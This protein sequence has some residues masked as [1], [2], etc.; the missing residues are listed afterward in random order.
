MYN[1]E[2]LY[3]EKIDLDTLLSDSNI[4]IAHNNFE[5]AITET[6]NTH[7]PMKKRKT[8]PKPAPFM[9]KELRKAVYKKR[10]LH[11]TFLKCKSDKNWE[12]CRKQRNYVTKIKRLSIKKYFYE[13]CIGGPKSSDFW[14]TIKPLLSNKG[15]ICNKDII[16]EENDK[17]INDQTEVATT[18]NNF[19][20]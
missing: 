20:Y 2:N 4:D 1:R 13:R 18:F 9:N 14:P 3:L 10:M 17:I 15:N 12:E 8:A 6:I 11:N 5:S 19:F 7:A 16:L